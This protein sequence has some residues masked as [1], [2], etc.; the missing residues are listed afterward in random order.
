MELSV[1]TED[2]VNAL[3]LAQDTARS[4][5]HSFVG[6]EHLLMGLVKCADRT[7]DLLIKF[8]ITEENCTPYVDTVVGGGRSVFTDSFGNTPSVKRILELALYEAKSSGNSLVGTEHILLSIMRERDSLGSKIIGALCRD[9]GALREALLNGRFDPVP[10]D[11]DRDDDRLPAVHSRRATPVLDAYTRDLTELAGKGKLDPVIGREN[12]ISRVIRT[13]CRRTKSN[14][15]LI[16][17]PGVGKS[18]VADGIAQKIVEGSVPAAL[19][20]SRL[21]SLDLTAMIAG[22]KYRGEFEER[23]KNAIDELKEHEEIILFIDEIHNIVGA[24]SGEGSL[25]AANILKPALARG[26]LRVIGATT[27]SE[28]RTYI[29]KDAALERRFT[30]VLVNEPTPDQAFEILYGLKERYEKHHG[31]VIGDEAVRDAVELSVR[32]IADRRLPDKAI[33]LLDESCA[34]ARIRA[35][36]NNEVEK[37]LEA[38]DYELAKKLRDSRSGSSVRVEK[39]DFYAV[40]SEKTGIDVRAL[41][42]SELFSDS[43]R[44][45]KERIFGQDDAVDSI[46]GVLKRCSSGLS[47]PERPLASFVLCGPTGT[48]KHTSAKLLADRYFGGSLLEINGSEYSDEHSVYRLIGAPAGYKD[49]E[50]GGTLTEFVRLHPFSV[51]VVAGPGLAGD[52]TLELFSEIGRTGVVKDGRDRTVSFRN[53]VL[54]YLIDQDINNRAIGF[55]GTSD[56]P[57]WRSIVPSLLLSSCDAVVR[58]NQLD[59]ASLREIARRTLLSISKRAAKRN[60]ELTFSEEAVNGLAFSGGGKASEIERSASLRVEGLLA[61]SLISGEL[62]SGDRALIDYKNDEFII[63]RL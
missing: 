11:S 21:L 35:S 7:S 62:Q 42:G 5:G 34:C 50:K 39:E 45:L 32:F 48:G 41:S 29:E 53:C 23:L 8:G 61:D 26:E 54:F 20:G 31:T 33:D 1:Y 16:G 10:A 13:L 4:F 12:E 25:D 52:G 63:E 17:E 40:L 6:S 57:G 43:A 15:V 55:G 9:T 44:D 28:Y 47:D 30:P 37:A 27:V 18:A 2:A 59:E 51:I 14:P 60:V 56:A 46:A 24:G 22:T 58:F 3:S 19:S 49:S 36:E 38:G